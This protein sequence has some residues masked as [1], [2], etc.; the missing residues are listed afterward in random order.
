MDQDTTALS[1]LP[2][3]VLL[4]LGVGLFMPTTTTVT[5]NALPVA[6]L[7][8]GTATLTFM[9][10]LGQTIGVGAYG[11]A[12]AARM[13][14][15]LPERL[16]AGTDLD[17][18]ELPSTPEQIRMLPQQLR[19]VVVEAVGEGTTLVFTLAVPVALAIVVA[20]LFI[21]EVPLRT[22]PPT[23]VGAPTTPARPRLQ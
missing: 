15:V 2:W 9:R 13:D 3:M 22:G 4:G 23:P 14:T 1:L 21:P 7:G 20:G 5:Q 12:L 16:P 17:V 6:D 19:Q 10:N 11:A 8:V 18:D